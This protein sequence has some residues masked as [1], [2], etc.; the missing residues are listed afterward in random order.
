MAQQRRC[1]ICLKYPCDAHHIVSRGA[2]GGDEEWNLLSLCRKHHQL[3]HSMGQKS[4]CAKFYDRLVR[5]LVF[6][7][8][9]ITRDGEMKR[10]HKKTISPEEATKM[11]HLPRLKY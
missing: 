10:S 9:A 5:W 1:L 3:W 8:W 2:G 4:F 6:H 7:G 11:R